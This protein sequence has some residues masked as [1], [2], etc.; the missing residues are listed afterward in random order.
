MASSNSKKQKTIT[1]AVVERLCN[2]ID[3][4]MSQYQLAEICGIPFSTIKSI[5]QNKT[6][7]IDFKTII[8]L[9][10]GLNIPLNEFVNDNCFLYENLIIE[11]RKYTKK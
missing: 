4:N 9:A 3:K 6:N 5:M 2:I 11:N 1:E 8:L 10:H 7:S